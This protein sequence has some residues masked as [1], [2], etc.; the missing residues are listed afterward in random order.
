MLQAEPYF[1]LPAVLFTAVIAAALPIAVMLIKK[2][3][4]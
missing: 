4:R 3:R 1:I 2:I